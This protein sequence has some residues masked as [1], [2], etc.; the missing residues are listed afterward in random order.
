MKYLHGREIRGRKQI[1]S[2]LK[3]IWEIYGPSIYMLNKEIC[4]SDGYITVSYLD[5]P[6]SILR[7]IRIQTGGDALRVPDTFVKLTGRNT[8]KTHNPAGDSI[9]L[10]DL[11]SNPA[12]EGKGF[13][14]SMIDYALENVAKGE[15]GCAHL[16]TYSPFMEKVMRMHERHGARFARRIEKARP[17]YK[18]EDVAV[19]QYF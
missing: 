15:G 9:V 5:N 4:N 11:T 3:G 18:T 13:A 16:F 19:M 6:A 1:S 8:W 14:H 10:V 2:I 17:G 7:S 12:Y